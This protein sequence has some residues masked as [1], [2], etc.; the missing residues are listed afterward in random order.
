M[1]TLRRMMYQEILSKVIFV[2]L[3]FV[4]LFFFFDLVEELK[5]IGQGPGGAYN[6][7]HAL[8]YVTLQVPNHVYELMP[9]TVLIGTIFVMARLAQ[10]LGIHDFAHQRFGAIQGPASAA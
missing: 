2:T 8:M 3:G 10:K 1:K 9:I 5:R 7:R 6:M 4:G